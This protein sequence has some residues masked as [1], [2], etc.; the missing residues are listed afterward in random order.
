MNIGDMGRITKI[1]IAKA[2]SNPKNSL[3]QDLKMRK[4]DGGNQY[5][6]ILRWGPEVI[7]P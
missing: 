5:G 7:P 3:G 2:E 1:K 6:T 4:T